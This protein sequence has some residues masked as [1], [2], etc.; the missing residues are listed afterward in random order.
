MRDVG[1]GGIAGT[2]VTAIIITLP[3]QT[4]ATRGSAVR[5]A[6]GSCNLAEQ[7]D[8]DLHEERWVN[9]AAKQVTVILVP[10]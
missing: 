6:G 1:R 2:S 9:S 7:G 5:R 3:P 8:L 10:G 4:A